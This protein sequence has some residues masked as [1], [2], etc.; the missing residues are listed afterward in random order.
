MKSNC[1]KILKY[2]INQFAF[3]FIF[4]L[5]MLQGGLEVSFAAVV[6][7]AV[8][9][10]VITRSSS[11]SRTFQTCRFDVYNNGPNT[12]RDDVW[13][14][15]YLSSD[16]TFG[17]NDDTR[18]HDQ[19]VTG[20]TPIS[21]G[22]MK[23]VSMEGPLC[24]SWS[25][26]LVPNGNYYLFVR[27]VSDG[28]EVYPMDDNHTRTSSPF[29]YTGE[30]G[31]ITYNL[32]VYSAGLSG[33]P[34]TLSS[35]DLDGKTSGNTPCTFRF[36]ETTISVYAPETYNGCTFDEWTGDVYMAGYTQAIVKVMDGNQTITANYTELINHSPSLTWLEATG[37]MDDGVD[38]N[39]GDSSDTY[40]FY[41]V[42]KDA[43]GNPP[44][45]G[46]PRVHIEKGGTPISGS[47]FV[48]SPSIPENHASGTIYG[49]SL[50]GLNA[51]NYTYQYEAKD[52]QGAAA[53]GV[54]TVVKPGP[55]V[56]DESVKP[57]LVIESIEHSPANPNPGDS[58]T[59]TVTLANEGE[60]DVSGIF[61][62]GFWS[63]RSSAPDISTSPEADQ[64][65]D[66]IIPAGGTHQLTFGITA[67]AAGTY[68]AW[69]Y[70]D[71]YEGV[72]EI[73]ESN[74]G[75]NAGPAPSGYSWTVGG[76][77][78]LVYPN[79]PTNVLGGDLGGV[80]ELSIGIVCGSDAAWVEIEAVGESYAGDNYPAPLWMLFAQVNGRWRIHT[81]GA[82]ILQLNESTLAEPRLLTTWGSGVLWPLS[83]W[84]AAQY[85]WVARDSAG[86]ELR[87]GEFQLGQLN[88]RGGTVGAGRPV[89]LL[90]GIVSRGMACY[91]SPFI[92]DLAQSRPVYTLDYPNTGSLR[93]S[94]D[95][96]HVTLAKLTDQ[97]G[98][99]KIHIVGHSMGGVLTRLYKQWWG[100]ARLD[101][102][103]SV[104]SP[105]EGAPIAQIL[106]ILLND[107]M[108]AGIHAAGTPAINDLANPQS[109]LE[110][111]L[112]DDSAV[113]ND[114]AHLPLVGT[115]MYQVLTE[116][117]YQ[118]W[119]ENRFELPSFDLP[120]YGSDG[121]VA[122]TSQG[123][124]PLAQP[125]NVYIQAFHTGYFSPQKNQQYDKLVAA[126]TGFLATGTAVLEPQP[127]YV[128]GALSA[129][130]VVRDVSS[131]QASRRMDL[132]GKGTSSTAIQGA[133]LVAHDVGRN[134][135][136][137]LSSTTGAD[138]NLS[139]I[140][141][142]A[143]A[144]GGQLM[145]VAPGYFPATVADPAV[146]DVRLSPD[147][148]DPLG[149]LGAALGAPELVW[150]TGGDADWMA[151][152]PPSHDGQ[153][154]AQSGDIEDSQTSWLETSVTGPGILRFWWQV[155]SETGWD[156][157]NFYINEVEQ[158]GAISG[159]VDWQELTFS[160]PAGTHVLRWVYSKDESESHGTDC[161]WV[162]Q[163]AW[164]AQSASVSIS[165]T[166]T[167]APASASSGCQIAVTAN[168]PWAAARGANSTWITITGGNSGS[169]NGTVTYSVAANSG[170][171][172]RTGTI[173]VVGGS[174]SR[175]CTVVQA[176]SLVSGTGSV[177]VWGDDY[178]GIVSARPEN[179]EVLL[180]GDNNWPV[181]QVVAG[182][183][184]HALAVR[185]DGTIAAW[186]A[187]DSGQLNFPVHATNIVSVSA[188]LKYSL[189]VT[190][191]K[192]VI[193]WGSSM[194][195]MPVP[196][197]ATNVIQVAA[198]QFHCLALHSD[199]RVSAWG[200]IFTGEPETIVPANAWPAQAVAAGST[201]SMSLRTDGS[202]A[203]W[204][205]GPV[206]N[207]PGNVT[208]IISIAAGS[209]HA[210]ALTDQG[211]VL[212]WGRGGS[213]DLGP[214]YSA[215]NVPANLS[216]VVSIAA[217]FGHSLAMKEDGTV[218]RWGCTPPCV[219]TPADLTN[220]V[221]ITSGL[222]NGYAVIQAGTSAAL[223][224]QPTGTN[225][226]ASASSG[227]QIAVTANAPW[228]AARGANSTWITITGGSSGS[229][230]GTVTYSVEANSG[231]SARTGTIVVVGGGV[232]RTC[233]VIQAASPFGDEWIQNPANGNWYRLTSVAMYWDQAEAEAQSAGG[234][235]TTIR[236]Q[237]ENDWLLANFGQEA[238][239][240]G[241]HQPNG[242][243]E[244][245][246]GWVWL[247]GSSATYRNWYAGE[248]NNSGGIESVAMIHPATHNDPG[249]WNDEF[250]SRYPLFGIIET[251]DA[252]TPS[253]SISP[254]G[255][256]VPA[257]ASS[258]RQ[259][260][261]T[262]NVPWTAARGANST[263]ITITSGASGTGN[264]TVTYSVAANSGASTRTGTVMVSGGGI[265]RTCTVVQAGAAPA[266]A[267][268]P[269]GTNVPATASGGR[270]I[271][272]T[273]N[274][275][276]T[277][278]R[279]ANSTWITITGGASGTG[280][281]TVTYGVAANA[282]AA[283]RTGAIVVSGG[284]LARTCT[285][286]Q[287]AAAVDPGPDRNTLPHLSDNQSIA[288]T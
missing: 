263:W 68:T 133:V 239:W 125:R 28:G 209:G 38:P 3:I 1:M 216:N 116:E 152:S 98:D 55:I 106:S 193:G 277:A 285:V 227:R 249:A 234:H 139:F 142:D 73:D 166:G 251:V 20:L 288:F 104:G 170:A 256:N 16:T 222:D 191:D 267:L 114:S 199:G 66:D 177:R 84:A 75:N 280:N 171:L 30:S 115:D 219:E 112:N 230:N 279:G 215:T 136:T 223:K 180:P 7:L 185:P 10:L 120:A 108:L 129:M 140:F 261:V 49:K 23:T 221:W 103:V 110:L 31:A 2:R 246:G 118:A 190:R 281:G 287:A 37:Y 207:V 56:A 39:S 57:D 32:N 119:Q 238:R 101:R 244:P 62:T 59:F 41:V 65:Y 220:A 145:V 184:T 248:P 135:Y 182:G 212:A 218:V 160:L 12:L 17:N 126:I 141:A 86:Q 155:S 183:Y 176:G 200:G 146:E 175:T 266:L 262:A 228:A 169:G 273:A 9:N 44:Q 283:A 34:V 229:G 189:A 208:N 51:G 255:T 192:R 105:F 137:I 143:E 236:N 270:T 164:E 153:G 113:V 167:N 253:V 257:T 15:F 211:R 18:F 148:E 42:Y 271:S 237:A 196:N 63:D 213:S 165:P 198:G 128:Q 203:V 245:G 122:W 26:G 286:V 259:I 92:A 187:N 58:V 72:S 127:E 47:P 81:A 19:L 27:V 77:V 40:Y 150:N 284:G 11:A 50:N 268:H 6:D 201:F 250:V 275:P 264:G 89:L 54:A 100:G 172:A 36:N 202:V 88:R 235:L 156:F 117:E 151:V 197:S 154:S 14:D 195:A 178:N 278:A 46:Y 61:N 48:M 90:H 254:T 206:T 173:V 205:R 79:T 144:I 179:L 247:S 157:L 99:S 45:S 24:P 214:S 4:I 107:S 149:T 35:A 158:P 78:R 243:P 226:P 274:V 225:V 233:T 131:S 161:G 25:E 240:I 80:T 13:V 69:A 5:T 91:G 134:I 22:G 70:A 194:G 174:L 130:T 94:V 87:R 241:L 60:A 43:D 138:G 232:S 21:A 83:D 258:G 260:A 121:I 96:L 82:E 71:R 95:L 64:D 76:D 217:G 210:L 231:T 242:S 204:G 272:V 132:A 33:V 159:T 8:Q 168:A 111:W 53:N 109:Q 85:E 162:D 252:G 52:S 74:E 124:R 163:V 93:D 269:A 147:P 29:S 188:G 282:A 67:P 276:W 224:I 265:T 102:F 97:T 186:G 123:K 181:Y